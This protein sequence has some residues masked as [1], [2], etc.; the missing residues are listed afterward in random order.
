MVSEF[1]ATVWT[2]AEEAHGRELRLQREEIV[3][4][5]LADI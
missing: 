2:L 1:G 3:H 5:R 4:Q